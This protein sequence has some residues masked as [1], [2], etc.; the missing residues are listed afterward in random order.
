MKKLHPSRILALCFIIAVPAH[1]QSPGIQVGDA[2]ESFSATADNGKIWKSDQVIGKKNLVVYFY[3][4][5]MTG[6]CTKQACAYRDSQA[7]LSSLDAVVI[8]VSGDE[9]KN[10]EIFKHAYNLNFTLLSDSEGKIAEKFGVP[11]K[12]GKKSIVKE[13]DGK[14]YSLSREITTARWTFIIDKKG[15]L[16]YKSTEVNPAEDSKTVVEVLKSL[17]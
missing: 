11:V 15:K 13:V 14:E 6:G 4:A 9:V 7:D 16:V 8:G 5:A 3:P 2:V 10:L 12:P 17:N 1:A